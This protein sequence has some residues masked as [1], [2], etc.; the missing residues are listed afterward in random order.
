MPQ[1]I[2]FIR[3]ARKTCKVRRA[4]NRPNAY[5]RGYTDKRHRAWRLAVL[6]RDN[7]TCRGCGHACGERGGAHADHV[8]PVVPGTKVCLNGVSRYEVANGQCLCPAC[9]QRKTSREASGG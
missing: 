5:Q 1:R 8:S 9:H 7:W 2:E 4:E 6:L 3:P